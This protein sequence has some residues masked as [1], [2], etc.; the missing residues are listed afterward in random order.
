L[1]DLTDA[2][3]ADAKL[4]GEHG[5]STFVASVRDRLAILP[6]TF[7]DAASYPSVLSP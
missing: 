5:Q 7:I 2:P 4:E 6:D 3:C 1:H